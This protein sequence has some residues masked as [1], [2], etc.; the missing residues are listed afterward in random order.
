MNK[1]HIGIDVG[2]KGGIVIIRSDDN[3]QYI[4]TYRTPTIDKEVDINEFYKILSQY[5]GTS[6]HCVLENVHS[7]FGAGAKSN[8]QFGFVAGIIEGILASCKI[9]YT[10]ISPKTWQK[11]MWQGISV[12][13]DAKGKTET[14]KM[15]L[16]AAKKLFPNTNLLATTR[17]TVEHDGIVDA[18]LICE[19]S[20]RKFN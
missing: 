7:I 13:K 17:S 10:K 20:R 5:K 3:D 6:V 15:S 12:L 8:F 9:P 19:F 14:K 11:E 16:I 2:K 4:D 18:L 1:T